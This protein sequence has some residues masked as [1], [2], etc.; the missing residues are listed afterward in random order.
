MLAGDFKE[1]PQNLSVNA[2]EVISGVLDAVRSQFN[3]IEENRLGIAKAFEETLTNE[4]HSELKR[5]LET[6][7]PPPAQP[8]P[9]GPVECPYGCGRRWKHD[10]LVSY[11]KHNKI[12]WFQREKLL[13]PLLGKPTKET[14]N[15][16]QTNIY[17]EVLL[18]QH[19]TKNKLE[20]RVEADKCV[21]ISPEVRTL[22]PGWWKSR[23]EDGGYKVSKE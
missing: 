21:Q 20:V 11:T 9:E 1:N 8:Q 6:P 2:R 16:R 23:P 3:N 4:P 14:L 17:C 10:K 18:E 19:N 13:E 5:L 7:T 12:C 22:A 15:G